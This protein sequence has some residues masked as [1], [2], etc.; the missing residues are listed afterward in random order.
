MIRLLKNISIPFVAVLGAF[1]L[2]FYS[3]LNRRYD[4]TVEIPIRIVN[5]DSLLLPV[6]PIPEMARVLVSGTGR[7]LLALQMKGTELL[8]SASSLVRGSNIIR[9]SAE[10]VE[11][12][13]SPGVKTVSVKEP[14]YI[15]LE[16]D[17]VVSK[18]VRVI[19]DI[20]TSLSQNATIVGSPICDPQMVEIS[21]PRQN[22]ALIDSLLT[23]YIH[24]RNVNTDTTISVFIRQ[25]DLHSIT[26]NPEEVTVRIT[27]EP[28]KQRELTDIPIRLI[29]VPPG[30]IAVLDELNASLRIAGPKSEVEAIRKE[31][32]NVF[33]PYNRFVLEGSDEV[34][35]SV[36]VVGDVQWSNLQPKSV[37]LIKKGLGAIEWVKM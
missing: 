27:A 20:K 13:G 29:D 19:P 23:R 15:S 37:R 16:L 7:Q 28:L 25:P 24:I 31:Q 21:G 32:I 14:T 33:V 26:I 3:T 5:M 2:W 11:L 12:S 17:A 22:A 36:S 34:E 30:V 1:L 10:N 6:K 8:V 18:M 4:E 35:L 9:L